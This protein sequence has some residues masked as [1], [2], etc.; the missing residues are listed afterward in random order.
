LGEAAAKGYG[1]KIGDS[2]TES[3]IKEKAFLIEKALI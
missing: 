3:P 1:R 2:K